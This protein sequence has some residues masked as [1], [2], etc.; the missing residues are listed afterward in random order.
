LKANGTQI[1]EME[2]REQPDKLAGLIE[3]YASDAG[4]QGTLDELRRQAERP[5]PVLFLGMGGSYCS[6]ISAAV[7]LQAHGRSA[8]AMDAG[9]WL[10][11]A[12]PIWDSMALTI[13]LTTSGESAELVE[14][15]KRRG[16]RPLG[17]ICNNP[18]S[19]CWQMANLRLP[20]LA[21]PEYGNATKTYTN[22]TAAGIVLSS[23]LLGQKWQNDAR[24]ALDAFSVDL[25]RV[26]SR[27]TELAEF[28]RGAANTEVIGRGGGYGAAI[29]SALTIRE[30][31]GHR[32]SP[33]TGAGFRHGPNLDTDGTHVAMILALG[34]RADLGFKLADECRRKGGRVVLV[35]TEE[36]APEERLFP[37]RIGKVTEPWEAITAMVAA[38]ALTLGM[39]ERDGCRLPPRFQYGVMEQ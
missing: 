27:R 15:I 24:G 20:I 32:A 37:V 4:I 7:H 34:R 31:T 5:G 25:E 9:E 35:S 16:A 10:H 8:L 33:H 11:Y 19:A 3:I 1:L 36:H 12:E 30:M 29:M 39:C 18:A 23:S 14:L 17:L 6:A 2:C 22:A 26:F 28:C 21:G 38:Q 13:L